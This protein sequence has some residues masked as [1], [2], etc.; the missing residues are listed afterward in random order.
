MN[1]VLQRQYLFHPVTVLLVSVFAAAIFA[2]VVTLVFE[3]DFR[4][5][6]LYYFTPIGIPFVAFLLDRAEQHILA[7]KALWAID[8]IVVILALICAFIRIPLISGHA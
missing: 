6:L 1:R 3:G 4:W 8:L 2:L 5:F 7:S